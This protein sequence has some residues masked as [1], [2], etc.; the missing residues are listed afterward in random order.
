MPRVRFTQRS[1]ADLNE[2]YDHIADGSPRAAQ[3]TIDRIVERVKQLRDQPLSGHPRNDLAPGLRSL[4][5][6]RYLILHEVLADAVV[7]THVLHHARNLPSIF[8][9]KSP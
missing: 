3:S 6:G 4:R 5:C 9:K 8:G 1:R 2:I 7:I